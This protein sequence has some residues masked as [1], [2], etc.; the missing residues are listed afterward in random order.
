MTIEVR[1]YE[2]NEKGK[3]YVV[4]DIHGEFRKLK[5][6][7]EEIKFNFKKDRLFSVGDL[8][9]RG[10]HSE[11]ILKWMNYDWF[12]PVMG[13][14]EVMILNH[15]YGYLDE[16]FIR[17][18]KATWFLDLKKEQKERV[19]HYFNSLPVAIEIKSE[20]K[21]VGIVHAMCPLNS[22]DDFKKYLYSEKKQ[23]MANK[24]M[25]SF[26]ADNKINY[27]NGIDAIIVGHNTVPDCYLQENTY[28]LDTGSGYKTGRLTI[29]DLQKLEPIISK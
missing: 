13:N 10:N 22:W 9:D 27:V 7:L 14:H 5:S 17:K 2:F 20:N 26:L 29:F 4:G 3:D 23:E 1:H 15:F 8:C 21:K 11:D 19:V 24:A 16:D 6:I 18:L 25:W 12:I 28:L